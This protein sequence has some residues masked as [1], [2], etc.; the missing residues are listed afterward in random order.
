MHCMEFVRILGAKSW[1]H[2]LRALC[3]FMIH[4]AT[5][6]ARDLSGRIVILRTRAMIVWVITLKALIIPLISTIVIIPKVG[7]ISMMMRTIGIKVGSKW[8][9]TVYGMRES[10]SVELIQIKMF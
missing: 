6:L 1:I 8:T 7:E 3:S 5:N 10:E 4:L 2:A 9:P